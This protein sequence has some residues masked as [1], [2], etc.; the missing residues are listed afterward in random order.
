MTRLNP[1]AGDSFS[2]EAAGAAD[3]EQ[4]TAV[5]RNAW[6]LYRRLVDHNYMRHAEMEQVVRNRLLQH[7]GPVTLLDLGCGDGDFAARALSGTPVSKYVG[8]DLVP[9][10]LEV[11]CRHLGQIVSEVQTIHAS[12]LEIGSGRPVE[13]C[14]VI[15]ASYSVHHLSADEKRQLLTSLRSILPAHGELILIDLF[16]RDGET[17]DQ[18]LRR[19]HDFAAQE[20]SALSAADREQVREHMDSSDWPE[21]LPALRQFAG[22]AGFQRCELLY[23]DPAELYAA[24]LLR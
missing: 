22:E 14:D 1:S 16:C 9:A 6:D 15:L 11:A 12:L 24:I 17:R 3:F 5:F 21:T 18:F 23:R 8:V 4:A 20:F 10:A 13:T 19:F 2:G 7:R